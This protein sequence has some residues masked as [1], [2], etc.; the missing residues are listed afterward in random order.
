MSDEPKM[1]IP[2]E[3]KVI[4]RHEEEEEMVDELIKID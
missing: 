3:I 2:Y 4:L 1:G